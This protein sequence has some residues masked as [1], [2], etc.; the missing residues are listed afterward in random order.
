MLGYP[1]SFYSQKQRPLNLLKDKKFTYKITAMEVDWQSEEIYLGD[2]LG[3][4]MIFDL[5]AG[6]MKK[7]VP[8][9]GF[10][11][12]C[13]SISSHYLAITQSTGHTSVF[14]KNSNFENFLKLEEAHAESSIKTKFYKGVHLL[15]PGVEHLTRRMMESPKNSS[16]R[17]EKQQ[18][19]SPR[20][21][22][23]NIE[24]DSKVNESLAVK[25][26]TINNVNTL[27]MHE[28]QKNKDSLTSIPL[29]NYYL[30]GIHSHI[31]RYKGNYYFFQ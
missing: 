30:E 9:S 26:I 6:S 2:N 4:L 31:L 10:K 24:T 17:S 13:I 14:E 29:V 8:I 21:T 12:S 25:A 22:P 11:I 23:N 7:S 28:I 5:K 19:S 15:E 16:I 3:N 1:N 18:K 20:K 27:R